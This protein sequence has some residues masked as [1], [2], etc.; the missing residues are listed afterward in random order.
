MFKR[1]CIFLACGALCLG[2]D[3]PAQKA[4]QK[5]KRGANLG[6][7]LEA[8]RGQNWGAVYTEEDFA[9][10]KKEGFDHVR[11]PVRWNDYAGS[12]PDFRLSQEIY[13]KVDLLVA[14]AFKHGL[15]VIVN[16]HH[17]DEFTSHPED[18]SP[19]FHALW[20]QIAQH[21]KEFPDRAL[22]FEL[23][24]EPKDAATTLVLN[25]IY[26][27]AI[28][29]IRKTNPQRTIFLGPSRWNSIDEVPKLMLPAGDS[30]LVVTVHC[31]D[32][33][34][35]THQ[36]AS[37]A[38]P[39]TATKGIIFPGPPAKPI[40]PDPRS[41]NKASNVKWFNDY[42]TLPTADNPSSP[43]AFMA[44]FDRLAK[45]SAENGRPIHLGE[46]G[47]YEGADPESRARYYGAMRE[48]AEAHGFA[49]A[50]WDWKAG[51]KYWKGSAPA[52]G[53]R[54]ALFVKP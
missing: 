5:F 2:A 16:I 20:R 37:W 13:D 17:F 46:F 18:K 9:N 24:N 28:K 50:I 22:A 38:M 44:K 49:W 36:G 33:F 53:M 21:Y 41:T 6:N 8:P 48:A 11:L 39:E 15:N 27:E 29:Q 10:M 3:S 45:W 7:Y 40:V 31:Y 32:P 54:E 42:N 43:K 35:F 52:P 25:P 30:N 1:I 19:E 51:F 23:L 12:A 47:A 4:L 34:L 26:A 14:H